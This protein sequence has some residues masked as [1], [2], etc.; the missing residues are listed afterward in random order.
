MFTGIN[1]ERNSLNKNIRLEKTYNLIKNKFS[2]IIF[3]LLIMFIAFSLILYNKQIVN[4]NSKDVS[5]L[6]TLYM[7]SIIIGIFV[8][9]F[10]SLF[11]IFWYEQKIRQYKH[12]DSIKSYARI[13]RADIERSKKLFKNKRF[14][15]VKISNVTI[16][17]N[18]LQ[19]FGYIS[20]E[21]SIEEIHELVDYYARIDKLIDY[22]NRINGH[23]EKM[24]CFTLKTYPYMKEYKELIAMFSF[25]INNLFK[26]KIGKL[27]LKLNHLSK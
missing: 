6:G 22:E 13:F 17:K 23:L 7:N 9:M 24:Q 19:C 18:W 4:L 11:V 14:E 16:M 26:V 8:G 5:T 12:D 15:L 27:A 25:E 20:S 10:T 1:I 21:L 3:C 2:I